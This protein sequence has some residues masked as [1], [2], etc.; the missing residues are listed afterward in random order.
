MY[1]GGPSCSDTSSAWAGRKSDRSAVRSLISFTR[2]SPRRTTS[3]IAPPSTITGYAFRSAPAGT[4]SARAT[5]SIVVMPGV[6]TRSGCEVAAGS[7]TGRGSA[8]ATS[9]LA[10]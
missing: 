5:A 10:A 9:T 1:P 2:W 6:S 8:A 4:L 3:F 7:S